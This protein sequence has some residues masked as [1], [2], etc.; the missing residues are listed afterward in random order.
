MQNVVLRFSRI[1]LS[2]M[3]VKS[4]PMAHPHCR[5]VIHR[6]AA[7]YHHVVILTAV[8]APLSGYLVLANGGTRNLLVYVCW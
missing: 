2:I 1:L 4:I 8:N 7:P 5:V 6:V 3:M